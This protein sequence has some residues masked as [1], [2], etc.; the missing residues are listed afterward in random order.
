MSSVAIREAFAGPIKEAG[1][2]CIKA[3]MRY[4]DAD[5][6]GNIKRDHQLIEFDIVG[7]NKLKKTL[8]LLCGPG[9]RPVTEAALYGRKVAEEYAPKD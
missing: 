9:K 5:G 6:K 2:R 4:V 8:T 3:R 7:P 1:L